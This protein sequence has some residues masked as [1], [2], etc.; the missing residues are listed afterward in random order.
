MVHGVANAADRIEGPASAP[1]RYR[2]PKSAGT[3]GDHHGA[4]VI[5]TRAGGGAVGDVLRRDGC[6]RLEADLE[7]ALVAL[8]RL[9]QPP[10]PGVGPGEAAEIPGRS[11]PAGLRGPVAVREQDQQARER[12]D[13]LVVVPHDL[14]ERLGRAAT[15]ESE[16]PA[17]DLPALDVAV[18][19]QPQ[20]PGLGRPQAGVVEPVS[21][22]PSDD[23]QQ[24]EM[25][26]MDRRARAGP[27]G[28]A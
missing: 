2:P 4:S 25:A 24:V 21:E 18:P 12:A 15:Q 5:G 23:R 19:L 22:E 10:G 3:C 11:P 26:G 14:D 27:S 13:V 16:I 8:E 9:G 20:Q 1:G 6:R 7:R 28:S 17:G